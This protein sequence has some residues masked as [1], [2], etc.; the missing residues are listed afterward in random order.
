MV[1]LESTHACAVAS[2][3]HAPHT[4]RT[5]RR[6]K[7]RVAA[8]WQ[9]DFR[10]RSSEPVGPWSRARAGARAR[11][12][13]EQTCAEPRRSRGRAAAAAATAAAHGSRS[14]G[15]GALPGGG[16]REARGGRARAGGGA[17]RPPARADRRGRQRRARA[18]GAAAAGGRG[19]C[20]GAAAAAEPPQPPRRFPDPGPGLL[21]DEAASGAPWRRA[22]S[23]GRRRERRLV[24]RKKVVRARS[25][26]SKWRAS[27]APALCTSGNDWK[28][29]SFPIASNRFHVFLPVDFGDTGRSNFSC[30]FPACGRIAPRPLPPKR[31]ADRLKRLDVGND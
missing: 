7:Q 28:F 9:P 26:E 27:R 12:Q 1:S 18:D 5:R 10:V 29:Q 17:A 25:D 4:R 23:A 2:H 13:A 3:R 24:T 8:M 19:T 30:W 15:G 20:A 16:A 31:S 22:G 6:L 21:R 11:A 14:A